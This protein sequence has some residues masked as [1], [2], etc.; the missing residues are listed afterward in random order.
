VG[1]EAD[2]RFAAFR[3]VVVLALAILAATVA[4]NLWVYLRESGIV[5]TPAS[6]TSVVAMETFLKNYGKWLLPLTAGTGT[7]GVILLVAALARIAH[8]QVTAKRRFA[9]A[10]EEMRKATAPLRQQLADTKASEDRLKKLSAELEEN[11]IQ[12][13]RSNTQ[14]T[15]SSEQMQEELDKRRLAERA[16]QQHKQELV[17]SKDV[18][19]L[20]VQARREQVQKLQQR[21]ELILNSA[22]EGICGLDTQG[23]ATFVNPAAA[24]ITGWEVEELIGRSEQEIFG[25]VLDSSANDNH[26]KEQVFRRKDGST[27]PGELIKTSIQENGRDVGAVLIF[28]DITERKE[29]EESL[30]KKAEELARSNAE[31]EQF[32][33]VASHDLQEPLRKIQAFGDRLKTKC[34]T[35]NLGEGRDY[36]DRMQGAAARMQTLINDLLAFSRVIRSSQPF[37]PVD[38]A[39]VT[40]EVLGDLEVRIEKTGARVEV[41]ELPKIDADPLQIRQLMQNLISNALKFQPAKNKPI[42]RIQSQLLQSGTAAYYQINVQDNGIGFDEKYLEKIFA[43]FQRLHGRSEYEGTGVGLAVC[44]RIVDRHGGTITAKSQPDQGAT[45]IVILPAC[46]PGAG[47]SQ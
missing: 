24:K 46:Q 41:G 12:L 18:L 11:I 26:L 5:G 32:A 23:R 6:A 3:R 17:R 4:A 15:R 35:V 40:R 42:V 45:F 34:E 27:F 36:L 13:N 16:L 8:W 9:A 38:L 14:L 33:F 47:N 43:V 21:Y 20:H 28:K 31:L 1:R 10:D 30:A 22:G 44:R 19:E 29:V 39:A 25:G 2:E 7:C 37:V